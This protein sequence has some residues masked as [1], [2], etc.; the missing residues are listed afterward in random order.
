MRGAAHPLTLTRLGPVVPDAEGRGRAVPT[1]APARLYGRLEALRPREL[2][3]AR[4]LVPE[5]AAVAQVPVGTLVAGL[6]LDDQC[7]V[8]REDAP[9]ALAGLWQVGAVQPTVAALR[10]FLRRPDAQRGR[11]RA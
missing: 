10:L 2:D 5:A 3:S 8:E 6:P 4:R 1:G 7:Q 11:V 9:A